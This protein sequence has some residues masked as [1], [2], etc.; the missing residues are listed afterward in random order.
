VEPSGAVLLDDYGWLTLKSQKDGHDAFFRQRDH[1][2][3]ELPTAKD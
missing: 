2:V 1:A 3:L